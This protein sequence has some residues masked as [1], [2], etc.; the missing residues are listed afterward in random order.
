MYLSDKQQYKFKLRVRTMT[1]Q[2]PQKNLKTKEEMGTVR[3]ED[4]SNFNLLQHMYKIKNMAA[5]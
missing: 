2:F 3:C 4:T 1:R 5:R